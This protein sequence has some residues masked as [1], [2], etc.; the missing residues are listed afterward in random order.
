MNESSSFDDF[1]DELRHELHQAAGRRIADRTAAV[2]R[3][4]TLR[5]GLLVA[6]LLTLVSFGA[7]S[8]LGPDSAAANVFLIARDDGQIRL[9]VVGLIDNADAAEEQLLAEAGVAATIDAVESPPALIGRILTVGSSD[10]EVSFAIGPTGVSE[11]ILEEDFEGTLSIEFGSADDSL[12]DT[13]CAALWGR[14]AA[15][16]LD[17]VGVSASQVRYQL[18]GIDLA[19]REVAT[20]EE[21]NPEYRL[22]EITL[23]DRGDAAIVLYAADPAVFPRTVECQ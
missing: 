1:R 20:A 12:P 5:A 17:I 19:V 9:N 15:E 10:G 4:R 7:L 2:E 16:T 18:V 14:T 6:L 11:I 22:V 23:I 13:Y 21:V 3:N 8:F